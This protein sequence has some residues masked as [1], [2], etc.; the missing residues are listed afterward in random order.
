MESRLDDYADAASRLTTHFSDC[1][2]RLNLSRI[3]PLRMLV[4]LWFKFE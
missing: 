4:S 1:I 3:G 2:D